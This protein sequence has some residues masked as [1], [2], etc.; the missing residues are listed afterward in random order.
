[1]S[2][3]DAYLDQ[4]V[5]AMFD[6]E[7][8]LVLTNSANLTWKFYFSIDFRTSFLAVRIKVYV[9]CVS[10]VLRMLPTLV[11]LPISPRAFS[12]AELTVLIFYS[13]LRFDCK[14]V[15]R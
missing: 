6:I 4:N 15:N 8:K 11:S 2:I 9:V 13:E 12:T 3:S 14:Y 10:A 5:I 1:M 7:L